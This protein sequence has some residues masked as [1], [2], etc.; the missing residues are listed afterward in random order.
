MFVGDSDKPSG[1]RSVKAP[2]TK[3]G[4]SV[5][6]AEKLPSCDKCGSG[7]VWVFYDSFELFYTY[8][9]YFAALRKWTTDI[10]GFIWI[11]KPRSLFSSLLRIFSETSCLSFLVFLYLETF[12]LWKKC[13]DARGSGPKCCCFCLG[14]VSTLWLHLVQTMKSCCC[15]LEVYLY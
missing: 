2:S 7:I 9:V 12:T 11:L 3:M 1:F 14:F 15:C 8:H 13:C 5:G 4:S 6:N 10:Y